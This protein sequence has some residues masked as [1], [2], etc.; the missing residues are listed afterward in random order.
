VDA[1]YISAKKPRCG[2]PSRSAAG[3]GPELS[4][5][6]QAYVPYRALLGPIDALIKDQ[7]NR[8]IAPTGRLPRCRSVSW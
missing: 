8:I 4:D 3:G 7:P 6:G 5:L 1:A 2:C